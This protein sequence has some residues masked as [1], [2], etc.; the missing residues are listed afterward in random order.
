MEVVTFASEIS[1]RGKVRRKV[2]EAVK[3]SICLSSEPIINLI[4]KCECTKSRLSEPCVNHYKCANTLGSVQQAKDVALTFRK[5]FWSYKDTVTKGC[6]ANRRL[7]LLRDLET[8]L[9]EEAG[10]KKI[11]YKISGRRVCEDFYFQASGVTTRMFNDCV[12]FAIGLRTSDDMAR[13]LNREE[14]GGSKLTVP[15]K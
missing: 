10:G 3:T 13:F 4:N 11:D 5:R 15:K 6:V 14:I 12:S 2:S 7:T 8:L 9:V 1:D